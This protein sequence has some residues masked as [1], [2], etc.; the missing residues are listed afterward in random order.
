MATLVLSTVG[1]ALGGPVGG[2]IG[3]LIGQSFDQQLLAP[4]RRGP[5]LGDL[6]VQ[7]SSYGTQI[8]RIYGSMRV[9]G[10]IVWA[11]DLV[12]SEQMSGVKGQP[13]V[14]YSYSVSLAVALS[15]RPVG[16]I[17]RIWADGKLLRGAAGDFKV[18]VTFRFYDGSESQQIDPLI[19]SIEGIPNTPAYRGLALAVFE[20]LELAAFGNRIPFITF[21]IVADSAPPSVSLIL[22]DASGGAIASDAGE[23]VTG[24]AAYGGSV[25]AA[26]QPLVDCYDVRLFDDGSALRPPLDSATLSIAA[27]ELGTSTG[28][29]K[30]R[31]LQREQLARDS[32]PSTLRLTYYDPQRDYQAGEARAVAGEQASNESR[33]EL[34]AALAASDAKALAQQMLARQWS[35]R[36]KLTLRLPPARMALEPGS[37][38]E[39]SAAPGSWTVEKCTIEGF[40]TVAELRP[41]W[42]PNATLAADAG[43]IAPNSDVVRQP[44][45]LALIDAPSITGTEASGPTILIAASC[46][47]PGWNTRAL[48]LDASG[49]KFATET[50]SRKALLGQALT[51]LG[52]AEPHLIDGS[53]SVDVA[54][55]DQ[56][57]WLTSCDDDALAAGT[58]LA[59]LGSE[60]IQFGTAT[61]LGDGRFRLEHLL[62]G[63]GGTEWACGTHAQSETFC[64]LDPDALRALAV[65]ATT[66]GTTLTVEDRDASTASLL[67]A[68]Q[69][70]RPLMPDNASA[71]LDKAGNLVL[72]WLRRS[73]SGFAW[74]DEVD[75]PIGESRE[76]YRITIA[77]GPVSLEFTSGSPSLTIAPA[78]LAA[79]GSGTASIAIR[80]TGDWS[81]SLPAQ[82]TIQLP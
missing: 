74:V 47:T 37:V 12:E 38:V 1:T 19:G 21:E 58:N 65:P 78:D 26:V 33:E 35:R 81:A 43:R 50:A 62:R 27:D 52:D 75:A 31:T 63:R 30:T 15:S 48:T 9:A 54:L 51:A 66:R 39:V 46:A 79:L 77:N 71:V 61:A 55:A 4:A 57:Q 42:Q 72:A 80:Q 73:R 13:D 53:N 59:V 10:C 11:T 3:A 68:A 82:I 64:M 29:Q 56:Q 67:F 36:D 49:Q 22:G 28:G 7:K 70:V 20:K 45:V 18:P 14:G 17:G 25:A 69:S 2:A 34:P 5:R 32:V 8:P 24:Y 6:N 23:T 16:A 60:V 40:A 41:S 44:T 76:E